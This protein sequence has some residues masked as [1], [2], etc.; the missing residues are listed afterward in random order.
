MSP[1]ARAVTPAVTPTLKDSVEY[2]LYLEVLRKAPTQFLTYA[3]V[4]ATN[5]KLAHEV[6]NMTSRENILILKHLARERERD[7]ENQVLEWVKQVLPTRIVPH[8]S[9]IVDYSE[10]IDEWSLIS[11]SLGNIVRGQTD[12]GVYI[13]IC[14]EMFK[15]EKRD[16]SSLAKAQRSFLNAQLQQIDLRL[17]VLAERVLQAILA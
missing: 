11:G 7:A 1:A 2:E 17:Q 16:E 13:G 12:G 9:R 6:E 10:F 5:E 15:H 14:P 3:G 4:K 8:P